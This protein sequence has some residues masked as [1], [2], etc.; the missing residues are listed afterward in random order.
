[1][2]EGLEKGIENQSFFLC[3]FLKKILKAKKEK[4][5][6]FFYFKA[7]KNNKAVVVLAQSYRFIFFCKFTIKKCG[8]VIA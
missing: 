3:F 2:V 8:N 1:M 4:L 6:K 7:P 5:K